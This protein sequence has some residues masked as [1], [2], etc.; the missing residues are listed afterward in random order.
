MIMMTLKDDDDEYEDEDKDDDTQ[1]RLFCGGM[2][3]TR[4]YVN[5]A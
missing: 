2:P 5:F 1:V 4:W 3:D